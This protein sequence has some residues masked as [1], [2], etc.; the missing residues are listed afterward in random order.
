MESSVHPILPCV[1]D[2][3][4]TAGQPECVEGVV[5][6][7]QSEEDSGGRDTPPVDPSDD[8]GSMIPQ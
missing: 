8:R 4:F 2:E 3:A 5:D 7:S 1:Q 6:H